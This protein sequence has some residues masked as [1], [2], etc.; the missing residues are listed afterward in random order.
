MHLIWCPKQHK[1]VLVGEIAKRCQALIE[2]KC[3]EKGWTILE[4][5]IQPNHLHLFVRI[6]P[7]DSAALVVKE[8]KA[9]RLFN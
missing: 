4:W 8:C 2:Q 5:A 1:P 6:W 7:S 9:A 3:Q